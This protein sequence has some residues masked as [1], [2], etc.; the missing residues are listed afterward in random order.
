MVLVTGH[1][2]GKVYYWKNN[3][4][5][6]VNPRLVFDYQTEIIDIIP[7]DSGIAVTTDA[8]VIQIWDFNMKVSKKG[9]DLQNM[10]FKLYSLKLKNIVGV[11]DKVFFNTYDGDMIML[12]LR[13][14]KGCS[15]NSFIYKYDAKRIKNIVKLK[16]SLT[17][18][19]LIERVFLLFTLERREGHLCYW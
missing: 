6:F 11:K 7:L 17:S 4:K 3:D 12:N 18:L 10:P 8:S 14:K 19:T 2:D 15:K 1:R 9:I 16:D 13:Y 5:E